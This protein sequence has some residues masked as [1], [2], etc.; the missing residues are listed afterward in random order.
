MKKNK[1]ITVFKIKITDINS[2]STTFD[3]YVANR[4]DDST[5]LNTKRLG[6]YLKGMLVLENK[7][8]S[9][10]AQRLIAYTFLDSEFL[11]LDNKIKYLWGLKLN[12]FDKKNPKKATFIFIK[13]RSK[14]KKITR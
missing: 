8:F 2:V 13:Y 10:F 12:I 6:G 1:Q 5:F 3:L 11:A 9:D 14:L 4:V 7:Q